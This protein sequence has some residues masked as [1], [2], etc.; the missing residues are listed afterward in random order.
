MSYQ[1]KRADVEMPVLNAILQ[2]NAVHIKSVIQRIVAL[3]KKRVGFL[4]MTFKP[5]TDDLR[6]SPLVEVVET[7]LGKGFT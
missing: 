6:E 4:G 3:G 7:L 5:D 1:A 2:S